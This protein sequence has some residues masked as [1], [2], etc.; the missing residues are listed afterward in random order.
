[1]GSAGR[2]VT[3]PLS[4]Q[5]S[6]PRRAHPPPRTKQPTKNS[7]STQTQHAVPVEQSKADI[8]PSGAAKPE[9]PLRASHRVV[10]RW[11]RRR[12]A[13]GSC[14]EKAIRHSHTG[15]QT[16]FSDDAEACRAEW[17]DQNKT[18][19]DV[20]AD[21]TRISHHPGRRARSESA[22]RG[23]RGHLAIATE[24]WIANRP[25]CRQKG[26]PKRPR[27]RFRVPTAAAAKQQG[28]PS[29]RAQSSAGSERS[30]P[31]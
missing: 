26:C 18:T 16:Q 5:G 27:T 31:G 1:V 2:G 9:G 30:T 20:A 29:G 10:E 23:R 13:G 28:Q 19:S 4:P 17:P 12:Q 8:R 11:Y 22:G 14:K 3:P 6:L 21:A 7:T 15:E 25:R 24:K